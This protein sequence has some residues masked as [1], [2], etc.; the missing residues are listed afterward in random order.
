M[1]I[2]NYIIQSITDRI[3]ETRE[4]DLGNDHPQYNQWIE[5]LRFDNHDR[6]RIIT[7]RGTIPLTHRGLVITATRSIVF[8]HAV[9]TRVTNYSGR[10]HALLNQEANHSMNQVDGP[11]VFL[12]G[13]EALWEE[14]CN[15]PNHIGIYLR[16]EERLL[17][18]VSAW[19]QGV[20]N[21]CQQNEQFPRILTN[22]WAQKSR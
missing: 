21:Y 18:V 5:E 7:L 13:Q 16:Q 2:G 12:D 17:H 15:Y 4:R 10:F 1:R 8:N 19:E 22:A 6:E 14:L 11:S 20:W 3:I 9:N